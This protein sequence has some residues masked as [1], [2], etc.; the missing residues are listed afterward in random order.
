MKDM[1]I[2]PANETTEV[3]SRYYLNPQVALD[4]ATSFIDNLRAT[5]AQQN[6]QIAQDTAALGTS[7]P[8]VQ[9]GLGTNTP[10][11]LSYFTSRIQTP[12]TASAVANLRATAQAAALNQA[13]EN[14]QAIWKKR[15]QDAYNAYQKRQYDASKVSTTSSGEGSGAIQGGVDYEDTTADIYSGQGSMSVTYGDETQAANTNRVSIVEP[16]SGYTYTWEYPIGSMDTERRRLVNT[17]DPSYSRG[18][19]GYMYKRGT[20]QTKTLNPITPLGAAAGLGSNTLL[21]R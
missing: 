19:D 10:A 14:E 2:L 3:E 21:R 9:G 11:G 12:Q 18:S 15:Y 13:L 6:Q 20:A 7:V 17:D 1:D 4:E 16:G 8:S 5:Q